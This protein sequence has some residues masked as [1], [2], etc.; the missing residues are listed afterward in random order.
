M[1]VINLKCTLILN[2]ISRKA[3]IHEIRNLEKHFSAECREG[4]RSVRTDLDYDSRLAFNISELFMNW[5]QPLPCDPI[6]GKIC[7]L[8]LSTTD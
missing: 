5:M 2:A 4:Q 3:H 1:T 8:M 7:I 6:R